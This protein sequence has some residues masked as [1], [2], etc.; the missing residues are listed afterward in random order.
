MTDEMLIAQAK[1]L[2]QYADAIEGAK[3]RLADAEKN[4]T[5]VK[6]V[7]TQGAARV[8]TKTVEEMTRDKAAA[9]ANADA[10]DKGKMTKAPAAVR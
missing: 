5:R 1:W 8:H 4:G 2:P 7:Q 9:R 10:A 6:L 3:K